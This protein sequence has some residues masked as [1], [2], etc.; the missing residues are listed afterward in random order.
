MPHP[1][2][3][4]RQRQAPEPKSNPPPRAGSSPVVDLPPPDLPPHNRATAPRAL[5]YHPPA[6]P[7]HVGHRH[8]LRLN[9]ARYRHPTCR[10][11][12]KSTTFCKLLTCHNS[13]FTPPHRGVTHSDPTTRSG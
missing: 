11:V 12:V 6:Q 4:D 8:L 2:E 13:H 9:S 1:I 3:R 10:P 5:R 7:G